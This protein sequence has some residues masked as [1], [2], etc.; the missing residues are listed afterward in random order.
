MWV[1]LEVIVY[2]KGKAQKRHE[3]T[4]GLHLRLIWEQR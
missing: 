1:K 4:S 2:A 3:K